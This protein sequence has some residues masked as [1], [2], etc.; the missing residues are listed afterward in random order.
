M[1]TVR[2]KIIGPDDDYS[3]KKPDSS[4]C[5]G[6]GGRNRRYVL[7]RIRDCWYLRDPRDGLRPRCFHYPKQADVR[8]RRPIVLEV[9]SKGIA[10]RRRWVRQIEIPWQDVEATQL[11]RGRKNA[12]NLDIR[13]S[14]PEK[15]RAGLR[16]RISLC[17]GIT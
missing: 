16:A 7:L 1:L 13:V 2:G 12:V 3:R 14:D 10:V 15:Y 11:S 6:A 5:P 4:S 8:D 9:S 17:P